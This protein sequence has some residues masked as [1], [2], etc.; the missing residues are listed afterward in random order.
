MDAFRHLGAFDIVFCR[1]VLIYFHDQ[2]KRDVQERMRQVVAPDGYLFLGSAETAVGITGA[3][4]TVPG[5]STALF[6]RTPEEAGFDDR[7]AT[8]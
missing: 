1:N 6:Q 4:R 8:V 3:W 5:A 2:G 7:R